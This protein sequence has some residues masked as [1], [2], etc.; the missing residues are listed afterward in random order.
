MKLTDT[1]DSIT[2]QN[3]SSSLG[4]SENPFLDSNTK[5]SLK[6]FREI[7]NQDSGENIAISPLSISL[8]LSMLLNGADGETFDQISKV[9]DFS[10]L[11]LSQINYS[12]E[13]LMMKLSSDDENAKVLIA[14]SIWKNLGFQ[15]RP[16]F[17]E[18]G[19]WFLKG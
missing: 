2:T 10:E 8:A 4:T 18:T 3:T 1:T 16:K 19:H 13:E 17:L 11:S 14:N 6:L 7:A 12:S 9:L 5:F 15:T